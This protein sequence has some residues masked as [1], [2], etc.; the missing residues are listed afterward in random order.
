MREEPASLG[1]RPIVR[2][3]GAAPP[4]WS[5]TAAIEGSERLVDIEDE[6]SPTGDAVDPG[7][8]RLPL[9]TLRQGRGPVTSAL[10]PYAG[11]LTVLCT[12]LALA[13]LGLVITVVGG[14]QPNVLPP[15]DEATIDSFDR[16][17]G[18]LIGR[19]P[20]AGAWATV[21]SW[22]IVASAAYLRDAPQ[23]MDRGFATVAG[24]DRDV[25]VGATFFGVDDTGGIVARY[26]G[27]DDHIAL[28]PVPELGTWRIDV[29][30]GGEVVA[31]ESL[32]L[33]AAPEGVRAELVLAGDTA[34]AIVAGQVRGDVDVSQGPR[35]GAVGLV[36]SVRDG[37]SARFGDVVRETR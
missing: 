11:V 1:V 17:D 28:L 10:A 14:T 12:L 2:R 33:V 5:T 6:P 13:V 22:A 16:P 20:G 36:A 15:A 29:V 37:A 31:T 27:P 21:G 9:R 32:G 18:E 19:S 24:D 23:G 25:R 34:Y 30:V 35:S 26:V 3:S 4:T 7:P 8:D